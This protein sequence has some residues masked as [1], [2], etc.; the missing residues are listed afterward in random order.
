MIASLS[1]PFF[2]ILYHATMVPPYQIGGG[3]YGKHDL[4]TITTPFSHSYGYTY[5]TGST[6]TGSRNYCVCISVSRFLN[7]KNIQLYVGRL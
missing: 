3:H 7:Y 5:E 2:I 4:L 6:F 1:L